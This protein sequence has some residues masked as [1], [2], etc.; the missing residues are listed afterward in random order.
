MLYLVD[1][2]REPAGEI[3][4]ELVRAGFM[5]SSAALWSFTQPEVKHRVTFRAERVIDG[6]QLPN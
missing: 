4:V 1:M 2:P 6:V 5:L 3:L